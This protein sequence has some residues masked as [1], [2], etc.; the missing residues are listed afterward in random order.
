MRSSFRCTLFQM[1]VQQR[2]WWGALTILLPEATVGF[3]LSGQPKSGM[4]SAARSSPNQIKAHRPRALPS[5]LQQDNGR[6]LNRVSKGEVRHGGVCGV[7]ALRSAVRFGPPSL[8]CR[9]VRHEGA[10]LR[11][12]VRV[13][14]HPLGLALAPKE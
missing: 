1:K 6:E 12:G 2:K 8:A 9:C 5:V 13:Q 10:H 11:L 14:H 4:A 3:E 7:S